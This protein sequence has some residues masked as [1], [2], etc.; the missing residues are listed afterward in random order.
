VL[1]GVEFKRHKFFFLSTVFWNSDFSLTPSWDK[2]KV[3][4]DKAVMPSALAI[5][6]GSNRSH[7]ART[8]PQTGSKMSSSASRATSFWR[9]IFAAARRY[10][11]VRV[12]VPD[13]A[14][15]ARA[16][17]RGRAR[18]LRP[19]FAP[20]FARQRL[21]QNALALELGAGILAHTLFLGSR[22]FDQHLSIRFLRFMTRVPVNFLACAESEKHKQ[23]SMVSHGE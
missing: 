1:A 8:S 4:A 14:A 23:A 20:V 11:V 16:A 2:S 7:S 9:A 13:M 10:G 6:R 3:T 21:K 19:S 18:R 17:D 15:E 5:F 12:A 22:N